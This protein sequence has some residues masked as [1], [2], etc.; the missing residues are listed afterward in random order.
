ML[1]KD[2]LRDDSAHELKDAIVTKLMGE[3]VEP[4]TIEVLKR[5]Y[6]ELDI[7]QTLLDSLRQRICRAEEIDMIQMIRESLGNERDRLRVLFKPERHYVACI[8]AKT[9]QDDLAD[10]A[11]ILCEMHDMAA[12]RLDNDIGVI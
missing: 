9:I 7:K 11:R 12:F 8:K 4:L 10:D 1:I 5:K 2:A 3:L 6:R